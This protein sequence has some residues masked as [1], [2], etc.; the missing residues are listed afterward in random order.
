ML[1]RHYEMQHG[2]MKCVAPKIPRQNLAAYLWNPVAI[3]SVALYGV[4][5]HY[6]Y[7]RFLYL[8]GKRLW[9]PSDSK[10]AVAS[11]LEIL[12]SGGHHA[13]TAL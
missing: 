13:G 7:L 9:P 4:P 3:I 8:G 11:A 6:A 10:P 2:T 12:K 5:W 1:A